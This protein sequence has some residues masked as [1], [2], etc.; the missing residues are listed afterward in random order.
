MK[1]HL[2]LLFSFL[3]PTALFFGSS[4]RSHQMYNNNSSPLLIVLLIIIVILL[5]IVIYRIFS[6]PYSKGN[7]EIT[8]SLHF[9]K[10]RLSKGEINKETYNE[11]LERIEQDENDYIETAKLRLAKGDISVTEYDEMRDLLKDN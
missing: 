1:M 5:G 9:I 2:S 10:E 6:K 4:Q 8:D 3:L 7:D 11:I